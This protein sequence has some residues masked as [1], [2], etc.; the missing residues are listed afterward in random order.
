MNDPLTSVD[1]DQVEKLVND[2]YRTMHK[3]VRTF[4]ELP[5][6]QEV[7]NQIKMA[8]EEFKPFIP[9]IQGLR[10]PGMR[11]RHWEELSEELG[12][13][14]VPKSTLTFAKCLDMRLQV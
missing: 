12:V 7:A 10:N 3:S 2:C 14:I 4:H 6:V 13:N 11:K 1:A 8:I 5:G 9:L